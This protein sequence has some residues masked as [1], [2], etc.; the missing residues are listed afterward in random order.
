[1]VNVTKRCT[2]KG[3]PGEGQHM[4]HP[5]QWGNEIEVGVVGQPRR[6]TDVSTKRMCRSARQEEPVI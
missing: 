6:L 3:M 2:S 5:F 4:M 1:M